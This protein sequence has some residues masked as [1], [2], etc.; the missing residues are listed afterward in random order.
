MTAYEAVSDQ[1]QFESRGMQ[2]FKVLEKRFSMAKYLPLCSPRPKRA[3]PTNMRYALPLMA[4][5]IF[6]FIFG[7]FSLK[8][9]I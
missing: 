5:V 3:G 1:V 8:D 2:F 6:F 4:S 7:D 9:E